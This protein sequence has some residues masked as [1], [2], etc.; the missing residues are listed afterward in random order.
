[1]KFLISVEVV[2]GCSYKHTSFTTRDMPGPVVLGQRPKRPKTKRYEVHG[3]PTKG[4]STNRTSANIAYFLRY[5]AHTRGDAQG[6]IRQKLVARLAARLN[7]RLYARKAAVS[8][9][10]AT[11]D[12]G[13]S[14]TPP[15]PHPSKTTRHCNLRDLP[16]DPEEAF[17]CDPQMDLEEAFVCERLDW[18]HRIN[19]SRY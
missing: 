11:K 12:D 19:N 17:V 18:R 14:R 4:L 5:H 13:T 2:G 10:N 8:A 15:N 7:A 6:N 1:M 9:V 3:L 16:M